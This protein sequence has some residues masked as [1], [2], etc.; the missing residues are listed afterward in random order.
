M[1]PSKLS[2][3]FTLDDFTPEASPVT[4]L[5]PSYPSEKGLYVEPTP[6]PHA[7]GRLPEEVYTNTLPWWRAAAR[8]KLVGVVEW[9]SAILAR[10]QAKIRTPWLDTYFLQTS[11]LG[12]HTFFMVFLPCFFFFGHHEMGRGLIYVLAFGVYSSSFVKDLVC[13]PRPH[14]P[15]VTRLTIGLHH[16]EYGFPSTH[17]TN[18]TS[19]ALF[20]IAHAQSLHAS[21]SISTP[22]FAAFTAFLTFYVASIVGGRLYT[23]MHGFADCTAGVLLGAAVWA[24]QHTAMPIVEGWLVAGNWGVPLAATAVCLLLVNQHPQPVD[25]CP[26]F[27]DA[28]A[29]ISVVLGVL[30]SLWAS[31]CIPALDPV[32]FVSRT[33]GHAL[34]TPLEISMWM[35]FAV[36]K[37]LSGVLAIFTWRLIAKPTVQVLLPPIFRWLARE[38]PVALPTRRHYTAATDYVNGPPHNLRTIP[39]VIDLNLTVTESAEEDDAV[40]T[41]LKQ[42][43]SPAARRRGVS[44]LEKTATFEADEGGAQADFVKHYDADVLTKVV[45]YAGIGV[46][47]S[48]AI[49]AAFEALSWGVGSPADLLV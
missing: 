7:A 42:R 17:S 29:F 1:T 33:P 39:S 47:A 49:P 32:L 15:P 38:S 18:S 8:R 4:E 23:G 43:V 3:N 21:G 2:M 11:M 20:M 27:E 13:S 5:P 40:T 31:K 35:S 28:I 14:S 36:L 6:E 46:L 45:V 22:A 9:E 41:G 16:L 10:W 26:C 30:V 19:M 37:L 12:T 48:V 44:N 34:E 24:V 25:D